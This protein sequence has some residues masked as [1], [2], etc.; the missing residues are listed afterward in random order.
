[1]HRFTLTLL[2]LILASAFL[3]P[4][5]PNPPPLDTDTQVRIR[6]CYPAFS[7]GGY[8][9]EGTTFVLALHELFLDKPNWTVTINQHGDGFNRNF[10]KGLDSKTR[11]ILQELEQKDYER[12]LDSYE[13]SICH[14]EPGAW[15]VLGGPRWNTPLCPPANRMYSN[16]ET[17]DERQIFVGRT[18]FETD[19]L[20]EGWELRINAMDEVWVPSKF[21]QEIFLNGGVTKPVLILGEGVDTDFFDPKIAGRSFDHLKP[22][23]ET[24][25]F[26]SV[27]KFEERKGYDVL[28]DS[29][30]T[31]FTQNDDVL[32][33]LL[34]S[35]YHGSGLAS[36]KAYTE[37]LGY[38]VD[39]GPKIKVV[40]D[41]PQQKL[42]DL[43]AAADAFVLPSRGEGWGRPHVEAM[44]MALPILVTNFSGP[45]EFITSEN[46][47]PIQVEEMVEL[48]EGA[49]RGHRWAEPSRENLRFNMAMVF[50][51]REVGI[52]RGKQARRDMVTRFAPKI[53]AQEVIDRV[54]VLVNS[55]RLENKRSSKKSEEL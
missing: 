52:R 4:T 25:V 20:P 45:T 33:L 39:S 54:E 11:N 7:G 18:M 30:F 46:S 37:K 5:Q 15:N 38:D 31:T 6:W 24:F 41:I 13:V 26:L 10:L 40:H 19:R 21:S 2:S 27:F 9:S 44:S 53:I 32:L 47:F 51:H 14:S 12:G 22:T 29:Y 42:P 8:S 55:R 35:D 28:L 36:L 49:F 16:R 23:S 34:I 48:K 50:R 43:Y 1:M 3:P 17:Q